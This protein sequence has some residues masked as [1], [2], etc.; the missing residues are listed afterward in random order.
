MSFHARLLADTARERAELQGLPIVQRALAGRIRREEYAAF[1][2]QAFHHV[3][4]TVPLLMACGARLP[5]RHEWLR[6]AVAEYIEEEIGH[7]EWILDDLEALGE[8]RARWAE[9]TPLHA[10]ELMVAYAYDGIARVSPLSFF[11]MVL[12]LEGTSVALATR[13]AEA[14]ERSLGLPRTAFTY[15]RSHGDLD[16]EHTGFYERLMD[17][18]EDPA[19][20]AVIIHAARRF[21]RL[22]ADIFRSIEAGAQLA[23][24]A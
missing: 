22:Y 8:D 15:L 12:V 17:R 5:A 6:R 13:A 14:I 20:Q 4:H 11:G 24:A 10:T 21:Y 9:S 1:L 3:R 18:I 2:G 16:I 7:E 23:E 19:E